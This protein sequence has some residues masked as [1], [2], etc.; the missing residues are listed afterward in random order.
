MEGWGRK[1]KMEGSEDL[2][3][4]FQ[5]EKVEN[6]P[7]LCFD[8]RWR[9]GGGLGTSVS[10]FDTREAQ[11]DG[12]QN[13]SSKNE[14]INININPYQQALPVMHSFETFLCC[15]NPHHF[16]SILMTAKLDPPHIDVLS[17]TT[18][19]TYGPVRHFKDTEI[20]SYYPPTMFKVCSSSL[21]FAPL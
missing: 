12:N 2:C 21:S 9:A 14:I 13:N 6:S 19:G 17:D 15:T 4:V 16:S 18:H 20:K 1:H 8:T 7:P 3:L 5:C 11:H 10:H